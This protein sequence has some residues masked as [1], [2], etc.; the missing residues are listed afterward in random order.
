MV[1]YFI[2]VNIRNEEELQKLIDCD[3]IE[4][5]HIEDVRKV[6]RRD[7]PTWA[8]LGETTTIELFWMGSERRKILEAGLPLCIT[9][10]TRS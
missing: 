5:E 3:L 1:N 4:P 2:S 10:D 8:T 9:R 6:I 7:M